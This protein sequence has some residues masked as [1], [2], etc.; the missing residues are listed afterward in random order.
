MS[1]LCTLYVM[2]RLS[3]CLDIISMALSGCCQRTKKINTHV[4]VSLSRSR[5]AGGLNCDDA[6]A[7][8]LKLSG[9][10]GRTRIR[11]GERREGEK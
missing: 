1:I 9:I 11:D 7:S 8:Q 5:P 3:P 10:R 4:I 2:C 6:P